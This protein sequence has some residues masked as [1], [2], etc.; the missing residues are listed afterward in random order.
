MLVLGSLTACSSSADV[1]ARDFNFSFS[2]GYGEHDNELNSF[3]DTLTKDMVV[4][5]PITVSLELSA[6]ELKIIEDKIAELKPFENEAS[7]DVWM[8]SV[9]C[10]HYSLTVEYAETS[11]EAEWDCKDNG[12]NRAELVDFMTKFIEAQEEY[13]ALP[14]ARGGYSGVFRER[15]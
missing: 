14:E 9:P 8:I 5:D 1:H 11:G 3:Y 6:E 15:V 10:A 12:G 7:G 2:Y 4:D 13:Q